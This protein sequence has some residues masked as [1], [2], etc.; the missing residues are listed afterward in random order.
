[1]LAEHFDKPHW[2]TRGAYSP[3][4]AGLLETSNNE[5]LIKYC[6][7]NQVHLLS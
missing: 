2:K 6:C 1:M 4:E 3:L 7:Y 5:H